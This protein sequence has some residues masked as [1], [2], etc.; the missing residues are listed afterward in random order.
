MRILS[1]FQMILEFFLILCRIGN[2]MF[3]FLGL[4]SKACRRRFVCEM[5]FRAKANPLTAM[6]FRIVGRSFFEK[7][8]NANNE[9]GTAHSYK[10]C[11]AVNSECVFIE[12]ENENTTEEAEAESETQQEETVEEAGE[13]NAAVDDLNVDLPADDANNSLEDNNNDIE[14]RANYQNLQAERRN[15]FWRRVRGDRHLKI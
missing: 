10:E 1:Q 14:E 6:A 7:Y 5:E 2:F 8:T 15:A 3:M 12:N 4:D 13:E 11:A 9:L